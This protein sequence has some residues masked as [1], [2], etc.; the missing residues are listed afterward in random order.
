MGEYKEYTIDELIEVLNA[1]K[2]EMGGKTKVYMS[3]VEF[4]SKQTMFELSTVDD[5]KELYIFYEAHEGVWE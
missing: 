1:Y 5:E 3:D 4:N 2:A